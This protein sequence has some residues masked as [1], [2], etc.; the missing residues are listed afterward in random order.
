M[1]VESC[2]HEVPCKTM[3]ATTLKEIVER[4]TFALEERNI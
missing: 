4:C 2:Y 1:I 3:Q